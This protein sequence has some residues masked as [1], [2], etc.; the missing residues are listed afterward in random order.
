MT[1]FGW[2]YP[3]GASMDPSA[4]YN[5]SDDICPVC[6]VDAY[7]CDCAECPTCGVVGGPECHEAHG[8]PYRS[9]SVHALCEHLG[10]HPIQD[11]LR[12][13]ER[14]N[15]EHVWLRL[16]TGERI[17]YHSDRLAQVRPW[18]RIAEVGVSGIA[19]DGTDWEYTEMVPAGEWDRL[20]KARDNFADA[21]EEHQTM[22]SEY[23]DD[24]EPEDGAWPGSVDPDEQRHQSWMYDR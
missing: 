12:A 7:D 3:P 23:E 2:S 17:Y 10:I 21:L 13:V 1:D 16:A 4:P 9:D 19:W 11:A 15:T 20:D 18:W 14:H 5:Q 24:G 8:L 6:G 22:M